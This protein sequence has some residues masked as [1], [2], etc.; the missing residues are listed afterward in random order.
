MRK[1]LDYDD[2][3][4]ESGRETEQSHKRLLAFLNLHYA[5]ADRVI[6]DLGAIR[7]D[8]HGGRLHALLSEPL[9]MNEIDCLRLCGFVNCLKR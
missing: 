6:Q 9:G 3:Q 8:Y 7:V 5:T 2:A 1:L 4:L